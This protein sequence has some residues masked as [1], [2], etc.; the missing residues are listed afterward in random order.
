MPEDFIPDDPPDVEPIPI[1]GGM[2]GGGEV[3]ASM[4]IVRDAIAASL[5]SV[6]REYLPPGTDP[7]Y[8][9][10]IACAGLDV[11][12]V[13]S[14]SEGLIALAESLARMIQTPRG[15]LIDAPERGIDLRSYLNRGTTLARLRE[16]EGAIRSEW[17]RDD[18]VDTIDLRVAYDQ[19]TQTIT[20][21]AR[22]VARTGEAFDL[23]LRLADA[24]LLL[25]AMYGDAR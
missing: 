23:I 2:G 10:D 8:G 9:S 13:L 17:R 15:S 21:R 25:E 20:G 5:A 14:E 3:A 19:S 6:E 11:D 18:R 24:G 16:I 1:A 22:V 4:G 12:D 7:G